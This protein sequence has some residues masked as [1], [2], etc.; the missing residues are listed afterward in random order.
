MSCAP[1]PAAMA[2]RKTFLPMRPNPLIPTLTGMQSLLSENERCRAA[3]ALLHRPAC[4]AEAI[5]EGQPEA[6]QETGEMGH[7]GKN[8]PHSVGDPQ[9]PSGP[10][11]ERCG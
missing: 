6:G 11:Q 7:S 1:A 8:P 2:A 5:S 4:L 3:G 9:A 10:A